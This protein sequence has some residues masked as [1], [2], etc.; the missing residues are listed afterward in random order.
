MPLVFVQSSSV[1]DVQREVGSL[2]IR[3]LRRPNNPIN[4]IHELTEMEDLKL[5]KIVETLAQPPG[6]DPAKKLSRGILLATYEV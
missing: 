6:A 2:S 5:P 1:L 3:G 4:R